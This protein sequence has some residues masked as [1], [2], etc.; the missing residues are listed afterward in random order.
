M[1]ISQGSFINTV[2]P[3]N[4][5]EEANL[6]QVPDRYFSK[7]ITEIQE[8]EGMDG[9][10][11]PELNIDTLSLVES[12]EVDEVLEEKLDIDFAALLPFPINIPYVSE[13]EKISEKSLKPD[14]VLM[15]AS[16]GSN[17][18]KPIILMTNQD[19]QVPAGPDRLGAE[20]RLE[21][22]SAVYQDILSRIN[23]P[24]M[25][26]TRPLASSKSLEFENPNLELAKAS[27]AIESAY[28]RQVPIPVGTPAILTAAN[29]MVRPNSEKDVSEVEKS[30]SSERKSIT[31]LNAL[32]EE[33][34]QTDTVF[35]YKNFLSTD[36]E[37]ASDF[38]KKP[39]TQADFTL[40][41]VD[42][43]HSKG[44][45]Q[46]I[47]LESDAKVPTKL[48]LHM[49]QGDLGEITANIEVVNKQ[50]AITFITDTSEAKHMLQDHLVQL[51]E[52]FNKADLNLTQTHIE[53]QLNQQHEKR[54][55]E[56]TPYP[57]ATGSLNHV[58]KKMLKEETE[59]RNI[60]VLDTYA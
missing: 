25:E 49:N 23:E 58:G 37:S 57:N 41:G 56:Q 27:D 9:Q 47:S 36:K 14:S 33:P 52:T 45:L 30:L 22:D 26:G 8:N 50:S 21:E 55:Q 3:P 59:L 54:Q 12:D 44:S 40:Q 2:L 16:S 13:A 28:N 17:T 43:S 60:S 35:G 34:N 39:T 48:T 5:P 1:D 4:S 38:V 6:K 11:K 29:P 10:I 31:K 18:P 53:Q 20:S 42:E 24:E 32:V 15:D 51:R 7:L 19:A 46:G